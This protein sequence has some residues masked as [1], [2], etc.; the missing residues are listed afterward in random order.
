MSSIGWHRIDS[1]LG[2]DQILEQG[3][4]AIADAVFRRAVGSYL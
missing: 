3:E 2:L 1:D 4:P